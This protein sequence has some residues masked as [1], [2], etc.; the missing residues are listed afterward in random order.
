MA[1]TNETRRALTVYGGYDTNNAYNWSPFTTKLE[2]RLRFSN[3]PYDVRAG[4]FSKA[5]KGKVP[6]IHLE[7]D[8][9][10]KQAALTMGD[11]T[12]IT[13]KLIAMGELDDLN[14]VLSPVQKA[15]DLMIRTLV[16]DKLYWIMVSA[17]THKHTPHTHIL[18]L[19]GIVK[20]LLLIFV[21]GM[22]SCTNGS[23][24]DKTSIAFGTRVPCLPSP[25]PYGWSSVGS[26][27]AGSPKRFTPKVRAGTALRS[28]IR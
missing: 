22:I 16:E 1:P 27:V 23:S 13:Q 17:S 26:S 3:R 20:W 19:G 4:S 24:R 18:F 12:L 9:S 8:R 7:G 14:S 28:W 25:T 10:G 15:E 2:A 5:P 21:L 11:S 6:Y